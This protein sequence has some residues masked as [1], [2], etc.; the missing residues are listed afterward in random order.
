VYAVARRA[1]GYVAAGATTVAHLG[2]GSTQTIELPVLGSLSRATV[3]VE[4]LPTIFH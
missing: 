3:Q 2:T 1:G 4:A